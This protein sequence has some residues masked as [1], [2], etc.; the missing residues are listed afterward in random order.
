MIEI[1]KTIAIYAAAFSAL[2]VFVGALFAVVK[3]LL[4]QKQ[5]DDDLKRMKEEQA[6]I[7]YGVIACLDG[8]MQLGANHSVPVAKEKLE[9]H[10][11]KMAHDVE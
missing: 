1:A 3:W 6:I 9:K 10:I 5:Q 7:C 8:L 11:N 2:G 4:R